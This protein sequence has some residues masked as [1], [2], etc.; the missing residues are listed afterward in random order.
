MPKNNKPDSIPVES[1][2]KAYGITR[3]EA[4]R[5]IAQQKLR[6]VVMQASARLRASPTVALELDL[7]VK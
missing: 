2:M 5:I 1:V 6:V 7:P 4:L 3:K